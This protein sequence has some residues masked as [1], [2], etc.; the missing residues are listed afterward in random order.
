[1]NYKFIIKCKKHGKQVGVERGY[2]PFSRV[3]CPVEGCTFWQYV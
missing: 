1:M 3:E 2:V